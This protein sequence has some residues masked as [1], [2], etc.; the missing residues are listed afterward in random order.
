MATLL[1]V[2][3]AGL[4]FA[5]NSLSIQDSINRENANIRIQSAQ[6]DFQTK[7]NDFLRS[8]EERS[9]YNNFEQDLDAFLNDYTATANK[10]AKS[11]YEAQAVNQMLQSSRVSLQDKIRDVTLQAQ[12][13][14]TILTNQENELKRQQLK[15]DGIITSS[16][17]MEQSQAETNQM[18]LSGVLDQETAMIKNKQTVTTCF[19]DDVLT[20]GYDILDQGGSLEDALTAIDN[21]STEEYKAY[22]TDA[23]TGVNEDL[24]VDFDSLKANAKK[25]LQGYWNT[26]IKELQTNNAKKLSDVL[27]ELYQ[28]SPSQQTA[29]IQKGQQLLA[30]MNGNKLSTTDREKYARAFKSTE[31]TLSSSSGTSSSG[32]TVSQQAAKSI[33]DTDFKAGLQMVKD[34]NLAGEELDDYITESLINN[35]IQGN[36]KGYN[37]TDR[38]TAIINLQEDKELY[39][40]FGELEDEVYKEIS[41]IF[42]IAAN[43]I[44]DFQK[45]V[46]KGE[47]AFKSYEY[48]V[49]AYKDFLLNK[50]IKGLTDEECV[51]QLDSYLNASNLENME[52]TIKK[53]Y[54]VKDKNDLMAGVDA[55]NSVDEAYTKDGK[56]N[57][58]EGYSEESL[59]QT[60]GLIDTLS[61]LVGSVAGT[62]DVK[63]VKTMKDNDVDYEAK[64]TANGEEYEVRKVIKENWYGKE[65]E[66]LEIVDSKGNVTSYDDAKKL[67]NN[68]QREQAKVQREAEKQ[69][70]A[71]AKQAS[72]QAKKERIESTIPN[73]VLK[74]L[75]ADTIDPVDI[76]GIINIINKKE[77]GHK[78]A[79]E[80]LGVT[81]EQ[82]NK[83][84]EE[85]KEKLII[86]RR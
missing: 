2:I 40:L 30:S 48:A 61:S 56:T 32:K 53:K 26:A 43:K 13:N 8:L 14:D 68:K 62:D 6:L 74:V 17:Q 15:K 20:A 1:D 54:E 57:F 24:F 16:Q 76:G 5:S 81:I 59:Y 71:E 70:E 25:E 9:D 67:F 21:M 72:E 4:G 52:Y 11:P 47:I 73:S 82:W 49:N 78:E 7:T 28:A 41:S 18:Y 55:L 69:A 51:K 45:Q 80:Y 34:G 50:N 10:L 37:A 63:H 31:E 12:K 42:P 22:L 27:V 38:E 85:E 36:V 23:N 86:N 75:K 65:Y 66:D 39:V 77:N 29:V 58:A 64:F 44:K 84:S 46:E 35:V 19:G 3:N 79:L 33:F 60:D 83:L